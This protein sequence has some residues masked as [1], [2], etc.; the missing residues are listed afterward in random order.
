MERTLQRLQTMLPLQPNLADHLDLD[1]VFRLSAR[2]DGV[3][4][5]VLRPRHR[6]Q[7]L[8]REQ[9]Q[10]LAEA[11]AATTGAAAPPPALAPDA[12]PAPALLPQP[13]PQAPA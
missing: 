9:E 12:G 4:E 11:E 7:S 3:P 5:Q 1:A 10:A 13:S 8:R 6:V 2:L